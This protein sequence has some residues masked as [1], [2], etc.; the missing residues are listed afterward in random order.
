MTEGGSWRQALGADADNVR[1]L[2]A[3]PLFRPAAP[4]SA[5]LVEIWD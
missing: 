3:M 4:G 5:E 1:A 2:G